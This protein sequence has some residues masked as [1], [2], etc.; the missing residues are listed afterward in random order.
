M[1][2]LTG[3]LLS[4]SGAQANVDADVYLEQAAGASPHGSTPL[5]ELRSLCL[6]YELYSATGD[7]KKASSGLSRSASDVRVCNPRLI[8]Y[9]LTL[10]PCPADRRIT[11]R[12]HAGA[13]SYRSSTPPTPGKETIR[14]PHGYCGSAISEDWLSKFL[15]SCVY[16]GT[17]AQD[18]KLC[19]GDAASKHFRS[20]LVTTEEAGN[21]R[22]P[23]STRL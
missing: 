4:S 6:Y 14:T 3:L 18:R 2:G 17:H 1:A 20:I 12:N 13:G 16:I 7:W 23:I 15:N 9:V 21:L 19:L 22:K 8:S 5:D 10:V 11:K